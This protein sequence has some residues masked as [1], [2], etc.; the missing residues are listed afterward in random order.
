[1]KEDYADSQISRYI[2]D[3]TS[4]CH[5]GSCRCSLLIMWISERETARKFSDLTLGADLIIIVIFAGT[6]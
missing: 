3:E 1:M 5:I 2:T 4:L 6:R